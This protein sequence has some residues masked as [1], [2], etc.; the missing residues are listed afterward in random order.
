MYS[1]RSGEGRRKAAKKAGRLTSVSSSKNC[2]LVPGR[3][4]PNSWRHCPN[5]GNATDVQFERWTRFTS[6]PQMLGFKILWLNLSKDE[7]DLDML[8]NQLSKPSKLYVQNSSLNDSFKVYSLG[9]V[10][11]RLNRN[12]GLN[13]TL[14][15]SK[16]AN[17]TVID[18]EEMLLPQ[19]KPSHCCETNLPESSP[20]T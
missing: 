14:A 5:M 11:R 2:S 7:S 1:A 4:P 13:I 3:R 15:F 18:R 19:P 17:S 9:S 8:S 16:A 20:K 10:Q 6:F 12:C